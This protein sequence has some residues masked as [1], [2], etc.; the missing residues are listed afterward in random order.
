M[1]DQPGCPSLARFPGLIAKQFAEAA[2]LK[3]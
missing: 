1:I 3:R 2:A